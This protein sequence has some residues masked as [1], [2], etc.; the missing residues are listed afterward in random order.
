MQLTDEE[1]RQYRLDPTPE[2][3]QAAWDTIHTHE[4]SI[5]DLE[6]H[7]QG[8]LN[9]VRDLRY[10]QAKHRAAIERSIG[11]IT[12]AR[13]LPEELLIRIFT[14]A[15][16]D[17][18][19]R[20][21]VVVSHVCAGWRKAALAPQ[22]WTHVYAECDDPRVIGRTRFW[23]GRARGAGLHPTIVASYRATERQVAELMALLVER[24]AQWKSLRVE[25]DMLGVGLTGLVGVLSLC[26]HSFPELREVEVKTAAMDAG[27]ALNGTA[28]RV[29]L[30]KS[31]FAAHRAPLLSSISYV[32]TAVPSQPIFPTHI[33]NL[34][35]E[36]KESTHHNPLSAESLLTILEA[37]PHLRALTLSMPYVYA[38]E[39]IPH[40]HRGPRRARGA[41]PRARGAHAV[42][43]DGHE[44]VPPAPAHAGAARAPPAV[45]R[46]P[47][48]PPALDRT[49]PDMLPV[50]L[51]AAAAPARA[52]RHRPRAAGNG[53]HALGA[54]GPARA[55]AARARDWGRD[56]AAVARA[57]GAVP[58][59]GE[60]GL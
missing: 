21:P 44:L 11:L 55:K 20:G 26:R 25:T 10:D 9:D 8:L 3:V 7:I 46:G 13:R 54:A 19:T 31:T 35:L 51:R 48:V 34:V 50:P 47:R 37:L 12:L 53:G 28:A 24:S 52:A 30:L 22:V 59:A 38:S 49:E 16:A 5:A 4:S 56:G 6:A 2:V 43:S 32:S 14:L 45:P 60:G 42:R 17:G 39:Y 58:E 23:L 18:W 29:E 27:S 41:A 36:I 1:L 33:A 57:G 15:V 40:V